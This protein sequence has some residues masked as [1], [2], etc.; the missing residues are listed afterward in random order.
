MSTKT[1]PKGNPAFRDR[2]V[3][4]IK[5]PPGGASPRM[6]WPAEETSQ[7]ST[8]EEMMDSRMKRT[9]DA[10]QDS[11]KT[12]TATFVMLNDMRKE[13]SEEIKLHGAADI[14]V[15]TEVKE[16]LTVVSERIDG[17]GERIDAVGARVDNTLAV[18]VDTFR[19]AQKTQTVTMTAK[20][21]V[22]KHAQMA[23]IDDEKDAKK[24][25]RDLVVKII[26]VLTPIIG[27]IATGI[28][29]LASR[30]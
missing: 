8:P 30:C 17:L 24:H 1:P 16:Q 3:R 20:V 11:A 4:V 5:T 14:V 13:L 10:S 21:E 29:L 26:A 15:Q 19:D 23:N 2:D 7:H 9:M 18:I 25:K 22:D 12:S 27:L 28:T 6:E